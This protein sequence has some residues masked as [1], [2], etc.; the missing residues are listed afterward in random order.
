MLC[1][2]RILFVFCDSSFVVVVVVVVVMIRLL[3][4][5]FFFFIVNGN[6][7]KWQEWGLCS[8]SCGS[9]FQFRFRSCDNPAPSNG[10]KLC[11]GNDVQSQLCNVQ[12][13]PGKCDVICHYRAT[14]T[15][16]FFDQR[17]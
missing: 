9:G 2:S 16:G 4:N 17:S 6:W 1:I 10:G 15:E 7:S 11:P 3:F 14:F 8:S 12:S 13:C 5:L